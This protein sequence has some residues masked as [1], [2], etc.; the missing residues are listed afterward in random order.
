MLSTNRAWELT[1]LVCC[2]GIV[3]DALERLVSVRKYRDDGIFGWPIARQRL[4]LLPAWLRVPADRVFR[5]TRVLEI[6]LVSRVGAAVSVVV[7]A[8]GS[9]SH[10]LALTVLLATHLLVA[11]KTGGIGAIGADPMILMVTGA[12]WLT[13]ALTHDPR[14]ARAGLWFIAGQACLGY[15]IAGVAKLAAPRWRSGEAMPAVLSTHGYGHPKMY[16]FVRARPRLSLFMCWSVMLWEA[17]FPFVLVLPRPLVWPFLGVG[18]LF[19]VQIA[20]L[21]GLNLFAFAFPATYA[22]ILALSS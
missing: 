18:I 6:V 4:V 7:A 20:A 2:T 14:C 10:S 11:I 3:V 12:A 8:P 21:M 13:T 22:A 17:T 1:L 9:P 19:H 15:F 16:A 5:G